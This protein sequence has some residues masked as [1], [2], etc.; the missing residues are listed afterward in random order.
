LTHRKEQIAPPPPILGEPEGEAISP[1]VS[2]LAPPELGAGGLPAHPSPSFSL[3]VR[4]IV[5]TKS[6]SPQGAS[7]TPIRSTS[8]TSAWTG[9]GT[10]RFLPTIMGAP[11]TTRSGHA[12]T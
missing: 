10:V 3:T 5:S 4:S 8:M 2:P 6:W 7:R 11:P 1:P 12:A 9:A